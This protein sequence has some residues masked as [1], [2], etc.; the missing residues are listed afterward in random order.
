MDHFD[1]LDLTREVKSALVKDLTFASDYCVIDAD[2]QCSEGYH[3]AMVLVVGVPALFLMRF[4]SSFEHL[5]VLRLCRDISWK[6]PAT[7]HMSSCI[8]HP[9]NGICIGRQL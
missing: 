5:V 3:L 4:D 9:I 6:N 2:V 1:A 7:A 8:R